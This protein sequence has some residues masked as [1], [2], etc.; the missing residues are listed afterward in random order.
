MGGGGGGGEK[1]NKNG[2]ERCVPV[3][4]SLKKPKKQETK[5]VM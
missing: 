3:M 2:D 5:A 4:F 1:K